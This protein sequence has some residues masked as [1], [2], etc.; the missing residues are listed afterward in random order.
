MQWKKI[1]KLERMLEFVENIRLLKLA[2]S[3][4]NTNTTSFESLAA[5]EGYTMDEL[6]EL[7]ESV[8]LE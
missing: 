3:R 2:E 6:E 8:E 1:A 7:A 5:E 4:D